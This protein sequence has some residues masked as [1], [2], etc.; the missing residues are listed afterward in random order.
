MGLFD[1]G[2]E[3]RQGARK[4][5]L[6]LAVVLVLLFW[7]PVGAAQARRGISPDGFPNATGYPAVNCTLG[8]YEAIVQDQ[9]AVCSHLADALDCILSS[10][11]SLSNDGL[12]WALTVLTVAVDNYGCSSA[13]VWQK[14]F[15]GK[16]CAREEVAFQE[17]TDF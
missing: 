13:D 15:G 2:R 14:L 1:R 8:L 16:F 7:S 4:C 9:S 6:P 5:T 3:A 11:T 10:S 12:D 17:L